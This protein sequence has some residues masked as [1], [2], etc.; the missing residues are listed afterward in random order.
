[1][2]TC[3]QSKSPASSEAPSATE[4]ASKMKVLALHGYRQNGDSFKSKLGSLRKFINKYVELVFVTAPHICP[5]LPDSE[6]GTDPDTTQRSWWFN[7]DD[8][9]FKG[10]N[11]NGPAI[12]FG[13][14]LKLVEKIWDEEQCSGLLGFSQGACFVGLLCDLSARGMTSVKPEF[15]VLSSGFQSGSLVHLNYYENKVQIPS[16]HIYGE[17]DEIIPK[18]MSIA[19]AET[20]I[21][22]QVLVHPGGHFLPA[23]ATQKQK[24]VD[25]F[26][27]RL[28]YHLEAKEIENATVENSMYLN[29]NGTGNGDNDDDDS[30]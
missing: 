20:F 6:P 2:A 22:P 3:K 17:S 4:S 21:D 30:D 26:R 25:F 8:G 5:P 13:E 23:Q 10:T 14:S 28:Q 24:Y 27:E 1:M 29:E 15:A 18:A 16:L 12:G 11:K 7:K 9:T 19:L